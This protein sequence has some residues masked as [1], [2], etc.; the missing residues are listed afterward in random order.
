MLCSILLC[1]RGRPEKLRRC[2]ESIRKSATSEDYQF[3]FRVDNDD[4]KTYFESFSYLTRRDKLIVGP[5]LGWSGLKLMLPEM[6]AIADGHW[7][8]LMND[9]VV[10]TGDW[11]GGLALVPKWGHVVHPEFTQLNESEYRHDNR[12]GFPMY[13]KLAWKT[14]GATSY[15]DPFDDTGVRF[16]WSHGFTTSFLP[17]VRIWHD[18]HPDGTLEIARK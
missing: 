10:V 12:A 15:P 16:L 5:C 2:I 11:M 13:P 17:G 1:T 18:R 8:W 9:D 6:E 3:I 7:M 4:H 14:L